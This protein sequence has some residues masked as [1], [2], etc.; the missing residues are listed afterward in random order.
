MLMRSVIL[1]QT[2]TT[3]IS[4]PLANE[5]PS[6]TSTTPMSPAT[7]P[8]ASDTSI[9]SS[10]SQSINQEYK[11]QES[12]N[13]TKELI[14]P[15]RLTQIFCKSFSRHNFAVNL[16]SKGTFSDRSSKNPTL[17]VGKNSSLIKLKWSM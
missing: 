9:P 13:T 6:Q 5:M 17:L 8:A 10:L 1:P 3:P 4:R 16:S 15:D 7:P 2:S 12:G 14:P 11:V